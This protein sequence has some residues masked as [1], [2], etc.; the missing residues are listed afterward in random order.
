MVN[1]DIQIDTTTDVAARFPERRRPD[2]RFY[3][4]DFTWAE[5]RTLRV[6]ER[7]DPA[8]GAPAFPRRFPHSEASFRL[9]TME[10]AILLVQG[11]N[12]S[13]GRNVGVYPEIKAPAWHAGE[14]AD[15]GRAL[16][17][18]L[19]RHGY[20]SA[21]DRVYVQCFEPAEL[22]RLRTGLQTRLKLVQLI[23]AGAPGARPAL[24]PAGL[25]EIA[26]YAQGIGPHLGA[27]LVAGEDGAPRVT[28]LV[29]DAQA[30]G[31]EV[32]PYTL[33]ADALPH[34]ISSIDDLLGI[35]IEQAKVDGLFIDQPDFA[36]R[37][38][39]R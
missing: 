21:A 11:L 26:G 5:L 16:L 18:L 39:R 20:T 19:A 25:R 6:R 36:V 12:R 4:I 3:A 33:R 9:A 2:G 29:D 22:Q 13:T 8:S 23:E 24:T 30:A 34:S 35:L 17:E 15:P 7:F 28:S 38:L 14:G 27:I 1:H 32:H 37:F 10:E 31:L